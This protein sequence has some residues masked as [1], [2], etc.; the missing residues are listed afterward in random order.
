MIACDIF[1]GTVCLQLP[2]HTPTWILGGPVTLALD[3]MLLLS[4]SLVTISVCLP[5][6][7]FISCIL[8]ACF[9]KQLLSL[10]QP[11]CS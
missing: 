10:Q 1:I 6:D 2:P 11:D 8:L 3:T 5:H 9:L 4:H 7:V